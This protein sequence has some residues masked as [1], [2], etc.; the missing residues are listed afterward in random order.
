MYIEFL[1]FLVGNT[2]IP[3]YFLHVSQ[4]GVNKFCVL[5]SFQLYFQEL[6]FCFTKIQFFFLILL[7][8]SHTGKFILQ[9]KRVLIENVIFIFSELI[10]ISL[11]TV[12]VFYREN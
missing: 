10:K 7:S 5:R 4:Y 6:I 2:T 3:A 12:K 11:G 9:A 8:F 1:Y